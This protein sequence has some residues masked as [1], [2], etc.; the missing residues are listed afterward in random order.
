MTKNFLIYFFAFAVSF[1]IAYAYFIFFI[2]NKYSSTAVLY[3]TS[4]LN[5]QFLLEAGLR[6]GDEKE[7]NELIEVLNSNDVAL[8]VLI[9]THDQEIEKLSDVEIS[10]L[11][12]ELKNITTIERGINR[13]V[14]ITV[15][16]SDP[17]KAAHIANSYSKSGYNHLSELVINS[18][19]EHL[20]VMT[21]LYDKK[22]DEVVV[23]Q[24]T[25]EK[26]ESLGESKVE[27]MV[28]VK[29][30]R[31]R[32]FDTKFELEMKKLGEIKGHKEHL[33]GIIKKNVP[34]LF[35]V[36]KARPAVEI[37]IQTI[38]LKPLIFS[39]LAV[40]LLAVVRNRKLFFNIT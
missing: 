28:L 22:L 1:G 33:E 6:F 32:F 38:F 2:G 9:A 18:V 17:I 20:N 21:E 13:S 27:G 39:G 10:K 4:T 26:L 30:P 36:S 11:I 24:D 37:P 19:Q 7:L 25:I 40:L 23:L 16:H 5:P 14:S 29:T 31:Y 15:L 34:Q 12:K 35:L 8:K 3:P